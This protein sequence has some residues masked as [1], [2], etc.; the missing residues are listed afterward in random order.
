MSGGYN[1]VFNKIDKQYFHV[2]NSE[3]GKI[4]V[5]DDGKKVYL[6]CALSHN[7]KDW[8]YQGAEVEALRKCNACAHKT[9]SEKGHPFC[10]KY[11]KIS[12]KAA[13]KCN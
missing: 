12:I 11:G 10:L 9:L 4:L 7:P 8:E 3:I 6:G 1:K 5:S 2:E 13:N